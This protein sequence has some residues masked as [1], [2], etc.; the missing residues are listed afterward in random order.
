MERKL[1]W[2]GHGRFMS[3]NGRTALQRGFTMVELLAVVVM[4]GVLAT[5]AV[6]GVRKYVLTAKATEAAPGVWERYYAQFP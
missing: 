1:L 4:V 5:L 2:R 3:G 6:F